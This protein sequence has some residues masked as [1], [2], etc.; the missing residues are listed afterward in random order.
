MAGL[1]DSKKGAPLPESAFCG[2]SLSAPDQAALAA[3]W[4]SLS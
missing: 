4:A 2:S 1:R 3:F